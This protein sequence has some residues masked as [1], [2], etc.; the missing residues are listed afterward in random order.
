MAAVE[1]ASGWALLSV[2]SG[3]GQRTNLP[4]DD[5]P[6][7]LLGQPEVVSRLEIQPTLGVA[8]EIALKAQGSVGRDAALTADDFAFAFRV[9]KESGLQTFITAPLDTI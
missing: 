1:G 5:A 9:Y 2:S 6:R 4:L 7:R 8:A 3:S